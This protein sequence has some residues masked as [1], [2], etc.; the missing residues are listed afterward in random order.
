MLG[1]LFGSEADLDHVVFEPGRAT[2]TDTARSKL[3][4]L[5]KALTDRPAL[6]L[7]VTGRTDRATDI[8][9]YRR[10]LLEQKVRAAKAAKTK[11]SAETTTVS[12][13][14]YPDLLKAVPTRRRISRNRAIWLA[15]PRT[16]RCRRWKSSS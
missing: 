6:K 14:E 1:S 11:A 16:C 4:T 5:G 3:D 2:L 8:E 10:A 12:P 9:G 15:W 13:E 7:E